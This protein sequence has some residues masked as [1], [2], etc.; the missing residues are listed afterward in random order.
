M[1]KAK[2]TDEMNEALE[3]V[4]GKQSPITPEQRYRMIEEAAYFRAEKRGFVGGDVAEDWIQAEAEIDRMLKEQ[5]RLPSITPEEIQERVQGVIVSDS[6]AIAAQVRAI[7]LDALTRGILDTDALRQ[8]TA[9]VV[10][11]AREGAAPLGEHGEHALKEA[12]RGL[13]DALAGAAEA[14]HLAIQEAAGRSSEFSRQGLKQAM[15]DL[16]TLQ[17]LFIET[18][19]DAARNAQGVV[20]ATLTELAEHA[21]TSGSAVGH[22]SKI[23]VDQLAQAL[24][25]TARSQ[26]QKGT[27]VLH[28]EAALLAGLAAGLLQ[29]VAARLLSKNTDK[30]S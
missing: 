29:G 30:N 9:A 22:R 19:Q 28:H 1:A 15:D 24:K 3:I 16:A 27:E 2:S 7:T 13:D 4:R 18:L 20:Q 17:T 5:G 12:V 21:R 23:A 6:A 8:V 11:G 14:A 25:S 26:A 10:K